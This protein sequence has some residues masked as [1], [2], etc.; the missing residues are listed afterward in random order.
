MPKQYLFM[1]NLPWAESKQRCWWV[2]CSKNS[3]VMCMYIPISQ[4]TIVTPFCLNVFY[5]QLLLAIARG[6][7]QAIFVQG[8]VWCNLWILDHFI[9]EV[10]ASVLQFQAVMG[11]LGGCLHQVWRFHMTPLHLVVLATRAKIPYDTPP[12]CSSC[13]QS[14]DPLIAINAK[15]DHMMCL[16]MS[17]RSTIEKGT[18]IYMY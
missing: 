17:Q 16:I 14:Q 15:L 10:H 1:H 4:C 7:Q 12:S 6:V 13:Y 11:D 5:C 9:K 8:F 2:A 18:L 3:H